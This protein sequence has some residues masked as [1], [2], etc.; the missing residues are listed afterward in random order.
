MVRTT[1]FFI[2]GNW[3]SNKTV[4]SAVQW[5]Q[6]MQT[7]WR[8]EP[9]DMTGVTV[10]LCPSLLHLTTLTSLVKLF[11]LPL[12]FGAQDISANLSG[13]YTGDVSAEMLAPLVEYTLVGHSERRKYHAE[14]ETELQKKVDQAAKAG[15]EPVYCVQDAK[16]TIPDN[17]KIAAYEP[18]WAI[19]TGKAET[20]E[21]AGQVA[22]QLKAR[23]PQITT[24][25]YGG[26]VTHENVV[27]YVQTTSLDGVLPGGASLEAQKFY[28]LI[29]QVA[30]T[31][32]TPT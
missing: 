24:I 9:L 30:Q 3:K 29:R 27:S 19:G 2:I 13:A 23:H 26:S 7:L 17:C 10:I 21:N 32:R 8:K 25:I 16:M 1:P 28:E 6:D 12:Q 5:F 15:I 31:I 14:N 22:G 4:E 11:K 18:V 20:A